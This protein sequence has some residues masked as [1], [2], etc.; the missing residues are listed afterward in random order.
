MDSTLAATQ[1]GDRQRLSTDQ[2]AALQQRPEGS[3]YAGSGRGCT[4]LL[5]G[6]VTCIRSHR[7]VY[8]HP[9][10]HERSAKHRAENRPDR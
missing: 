6:Y 7:R 3:A 10:P 8:R 5:G 1:F 2:E 9:E 4:P